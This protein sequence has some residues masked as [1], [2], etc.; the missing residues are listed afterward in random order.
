MYYSKTLLYH[1]VCHTMPSYDVLFSGEQGL[2]TLHFFLFIC[3][4]PSFPI[5]LSFVSFFFCIYSS[6]SL[7]P[8]FVHLTVAVIILFSVF[9]IAPLSSLYPSI[10]PAVWQ[11][12][13]VVFIRVT[14]GLFPGHV[15]GTA[16]SAWWLPWVLPLHEPPC[17][18]CKLQP[19]PC[20]RKHSWAYTHACTHT[21]IHS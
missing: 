20:T 17:S 10:L 1:N 14:S 18:P 8:V 2:H 21:N 12:V 7:S 16:S 5:P 9:F 4:S 13:C 15:P 19:V 3:L 6:L 11:G